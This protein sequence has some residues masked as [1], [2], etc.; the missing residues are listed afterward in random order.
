[1]KR[2]INPRVGKFTYKR[3]L[4]KAFGNSL[5]GNNR[6]LLI[7]DM[8]AKWDD[9]LRIIAEEKAALDAQG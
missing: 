5:Y 6:T 2:L 9:M 1:M 4:N 7:K 3:G 8:E